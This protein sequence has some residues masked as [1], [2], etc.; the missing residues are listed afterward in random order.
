MKSI[1]LRTVLAAGALFIAIPALAADY[2]SYSL[3]ELSQ[4]RGT[5]MDKSQEEREAFRNAWMEKMRNATP[6]E[7][8][9]YSGAQ[10]KGH[11]YGQMHSNGQS[12]FG[13]AGNCDG[14]G[15]GHRHGRK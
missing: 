3:Q 6:E 1:T 7:R 8:S 9:L 2:S 12:G 15:H 13:G 4:M 5:M 10:G 11:K 14:S